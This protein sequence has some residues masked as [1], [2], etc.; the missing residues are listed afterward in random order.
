MGNPAFKFPSVV[1]LSPM[2]SQFGHYRTSRPRFPC[3]TCGPSLCLPKVHQWSAEV[4]NSEALADGASDR[5]ILP[6]G[7]AGNAKA[8]NVLQ[9]YNASKVAIVHAEYATRARTKECLAGTLVLTCS[10]TPRVAED[11]AGVRNGKADFSLR[12]QCCR[13]GDA[14]RR[15]LPGS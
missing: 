8:A 7:Q 13:R 4:L 11:K 5:E 2:T 6:K 15:N 1:F 12:N 14:S 10:A 3:A 9:R